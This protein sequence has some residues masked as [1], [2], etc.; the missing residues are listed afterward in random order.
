MQHEV[1]L[2]WDIC[3]KIWWSLFWRTIVLGFLVGSAAAIF[4][5]A[6][7]KLGH[8]DTGKFGLLSGLIAAIPMGLVSLRAVLKKEFK[9]FKIVL[10][11][12][13]RPPEA[14][15][16]LGI[17]QAKLGPRGESK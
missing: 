6:I 9:Y 13:G 12:T 11:E 10:M 1:E 5:G 16:R 7:A 8:G 17:D 3:L 4:G 2:T 14:E 15:L